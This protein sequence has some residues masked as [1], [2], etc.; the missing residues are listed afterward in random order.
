MISPSEYAVREITLV[1]L[2][3]VAHVHLLAFPLTALSSLG[4]E[5]VRRYYHW[6]LTGPHDVIALC[7]VQDGELTAFCFGGVFRGALQGF[8]RRNRFYLGWRLITHPWLLSN[9]IVRQQIGVAL[10][11]IAR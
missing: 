7:I 1:D 5:A 3:A 2:A 10:R 8:L 9:K 11:S 4:P 6:Q